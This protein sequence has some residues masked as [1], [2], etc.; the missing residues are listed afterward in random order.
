MGLFNP[1][2]NYSFRFGQYG[3]A[4]VQWLL[5][6]VGDCVLGDGLWLPWQLRQCFRDWAGVVGLLQRF[7]IVARNRLR[8]NV[9]EGLY[10]LRDGTRY[11]AM[12]DGPHR[13]MLCDL[14]GG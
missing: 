4:L 2:I 1:V 13:E 14:L 12:T 11:C 10:D 7:G 9:R 5:F 8:I 3:G 6:Y